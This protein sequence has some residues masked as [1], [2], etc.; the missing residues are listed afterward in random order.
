MDYKTVLVALGTDAGCAARVRMAAELAARFGGQVVGVSATG[1]RM[2]PLFRAGE[3]AARHAEAARQSRL[4]HTAESGELLGEVVSQAACGTAYTHHVVE[5]EWGWVMA[6][7]GRV[8]DIIILGGLLPPGDSAMERTA[9]Y[10]LLN[11]GR[12][13][14]FVPPHPVRLHGG[15]MVIAWDGSREAARAVADAMPLLL[16][17]SKIT[18]LAVWDEHGTPD[19]NSEPVAGLRQYLRRHGVIAGVRTEQTAQSVGT[20]ILEALPVLGADMLVAGG[21]GHGRVRELI[22][23]GTTRALMHACQIP[24]LLSH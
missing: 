19:A 7:E 6:Q 15:H 20:V 13:V 24:L 18:I 14:L 21:Y 11:A 17:A 10:V 9:E 16:C 2:D 8:A 4:A 1:I 23:G 12:P 3:D 5:D 22:L